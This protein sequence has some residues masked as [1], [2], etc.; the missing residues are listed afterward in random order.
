[1]PFNVGENVGA[2]RIIGQLGQGGMATVFKAYHASL[3]RYVALKVLHPAFGEDPAF[4]ARFR[5]EARVVAKLE[6]PNIVPIYDYAEHEKR[7]YLVMKFIEGDTLKARLDQGPL[8]SEEIIKIV[9]ALGSALAYAHKRDVLHRDIKPSNV[10]VAADGQVYL[11]DFG[12][13]R[14][15]Q[16][17]ESTLSGD[18]IIGTPQYISPEQAMGVKDLD[19]RTDVYSFGVMLYEMVV[20][21][22]PFNA[23]TPFSIIHD[24]I[25]SPLP[26]PHK[27]NPDVPEQVE[28]VLLKALAKN[29]LDRYENVDQMVSAF[30]E[31]W[32]QPIVPT[33]VAV[34]T[35][36][37]ARQA[38]QAAEE[39]GVSAAATKVEAQPIA[40]ATQPKPASSSD[41]QAVTKKRSPW[42]WV[43]LGLTIL[44]CFTALAIRNRALVPLVKNLRATDSAPTALPASLPQRGENVPPARE[45]GLPPEVLAAQD[46]ARSNPQDLGA[47]F[48]LALTY[49]VSDMPDET[50]ATLARIIELVGPENA[51]F[52]IGAGDKFLNMQAWPPAALMYFQAVKFHAAKG[53][54]PPELLTVFH[55][56]VYKSADRPDALPVLPVDE[57]AKVDEPISLLFRSRSAFYVKDVDRAYRQLDE[58]KKTKPNM[59]EAS[60][61]EA[62]FNSMDGKPER[63]R[64]LLDALISDRSVPEWIRIFAEQIMKRLP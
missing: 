37:A 12:L 33:Q 45:D 44:C 7:P 9:D 20:G 32:D 19:E 28:R 62:E 17:G 58:L 36:T 34:A 46:I 57:I 29:R 59:H 51:P 22:V 47:Q 5:R 41:I 21:K 48:D 31:A 61:L 18:M 50:Y 26:L 40:T 42:V 60:L 55:E 14:I 13:A 56:A 27:V 43:G 64:I 54:V 2:Y 39:A 49:W 1:M 6:H 52:Y 3:D 4:E 25:Y 15:A 30:R 53:K 23:D 24:H 11:A 8:T 16:L 38:V 10:L 35:R 63:A